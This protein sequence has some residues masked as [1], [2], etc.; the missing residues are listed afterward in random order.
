MSD[1]TDERDGSASSSRHHEEPVHGENE[2][3][4]PE[5]DALPQP[6]PARGQ[7]EEADDAGI[8]EWLAPLF[9][10]S[11]LWPL[12]LVVAGSLA[13]VGGAIGVSALYQQNPFAAAGLI[14]LAWICFDVGKR[15]RRDKG[16]LGRLGWSII[17]LWGLSAAI[18]VLA[19]AL[20]LV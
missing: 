5:S 7:P 20:G 12:V 3:R 6:A 2:T 14:G 10:D 15:H 16:S 11:T 8:E 1:D 4:D 18:G 9:T 17:A 13:T 19:I